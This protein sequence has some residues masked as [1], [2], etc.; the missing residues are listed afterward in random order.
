MKFR[1]WKTGLFEMPCLEMPCFQTAFKVTVASGL[2][3]K[4]NIH[5]SE[6]NW[7]KDKTTDSPSHQTDKEKY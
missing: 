3:H 6:L 4:P 5:H 2:Y 7:I 1:T